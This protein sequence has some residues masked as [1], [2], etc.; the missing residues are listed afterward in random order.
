[1]LEKKV[2][3]EWVSAASQK[4][5][6]GENQWTAFEGEK[7]VLEEWTGNKMIGVFVWNLLKSWGSL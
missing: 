7:A 1:M 2:L 3:A 5:I 6:E 4:V